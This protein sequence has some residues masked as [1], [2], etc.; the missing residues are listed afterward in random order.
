[1]IGAREPFRWRQ[2]YVISYRKG[3]RAVGVGVLG[4]VALAVGLFG[5][6]P[7]AVVAAESAYA[8]IARQV[9]GPDATVS[10]ILQNP[11]AD[12]HAYEPSPS[13]ARAVAGAGIV[14]E[15][16]IGYD[17]WMDRLLAASPAPRRRV[18]VVADLLGRQSGDNAHLWYDPQ[19][20]PRLV[21]SLADALI[22]EDPA[23]KGEVDARCAG[24]LA[25]LAA[26]QSRIDRLRARFAGTEVAATEP[27]LGPMI[28]ALGLHDR[29]GRFEI[30]VMNGTEPRAGDVASMEDDLRAHRIR[31]LI[32][33]GQASDPSAAR[34][35]GLAR[36]EQI[37][38]VAVSETL[39]AGKTYQQWIDAELSALETALALPGLSQ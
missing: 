6:T 7:S 27:V 3:E 32:V 12:P 24:V 30:S 35:A 20:M 31:A 22:Q 19:A 28:A 13:A 17:G 23:A 39:P 11:A 14:I 26:L 25:S 34:L 8:D 1:L 18:I 4:S 9:A 5:S 15:N 29:H 16:G 10:A 2:C 37:P 36:A 38:V 21:R 33:N